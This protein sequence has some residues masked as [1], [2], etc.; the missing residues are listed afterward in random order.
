M[1]SKT[2]GE[3]LYTLE[4]FWWYTPD[5]HLL[6]TDWMHL[7]PRLLSFSDSQ[8]LIDVQDMLPP[9]S[10]VPLVVIYYPS[11]RPPWLCLM[12]YQTSACLEM[13]RLRGSRPTWRLQ[14]KSCLKPTVPAAAACLHL[15]MFGPT[16]HLWFH[17]GWHTL[18]TSGYRWWS[19]W[20][21]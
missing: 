13:T 12:F 8:V 21:R 3:R 2:E 4:Y 10:S 14:C 19:Q 1:Q 7:L 6:F 9:G 18:S 16:A 5:L 17:L 20:D 15:L 11:L